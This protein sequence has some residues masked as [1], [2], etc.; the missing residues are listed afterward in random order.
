MTSEEE[1]LIYELGSVEGEK[2]WYSSKAP[3]DEVLIMRKSLDTEMSG[4]LVFMDHATGSL[5]DENGFPVKFV[6]SPPKYAISYVVGTEDL[7]TA[8]KH[9]AK[10][11]LRQKYA[12]FGL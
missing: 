8:L 10:Y 4:K 11:R 5:K 1:H 2:I 7:S 12:K 6:K 9:V 3:K